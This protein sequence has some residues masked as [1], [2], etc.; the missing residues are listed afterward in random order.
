M[1]DL[2]QFEKGQRLTFL[3][4]RKEDWLPESIEVAEV[5]DHGYVV[6]GISHR[7]TVKGADGH[8]YSGWWFDPNAVSVP[9]TDDDWPLFERE[10]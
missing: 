6:P 8:A 3:P 1:S 5:I 2:M 10:L 7:Y 4:E 9:S